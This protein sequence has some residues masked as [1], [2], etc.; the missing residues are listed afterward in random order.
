MDIRVEGRLTYRFNV[1]YSLDGDMPILEVGYA[2]DGRA[3]AVIQGYYAEITP[4]DVEA[5]KIR[6]VDR[7]SDTL[8]Y[9]NYTWY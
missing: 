8:Y 1:K 6:S 5:F 7:E 4:E 2:P 9:P 3:Y